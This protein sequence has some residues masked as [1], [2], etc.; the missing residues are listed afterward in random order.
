V[1]H[2]TDAVTPVHHLLP[3]GPIPALLLGIE[4]ADAGTC[5]E[6]SDPPPLPGDK[7]VTAAALRRA[8]PHH[9]PF[10]PQALLLRTQGAWPGDDN[11]PFLSREAALEIVA[12]GILHLVIDLPSLD[13]SQ[14]QGRLTAHRI[15]FGL[16]SGSRQAGAATRG[17]AT[18]TELAQFPSHLADG[19][20]GVQIQ[21]PAFSGDA[22]PSRPIHL[23]L[24]Q[25]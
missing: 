23:P 19:P 21:V 4:L 11:P 16:P 9:L 20:C 22:V 2:L 5:D 8:W 12:R 24:A 17:L 14:D 6:G 13:R 1:A 18:V 15:F 3:L 7:L 10:E 25:P